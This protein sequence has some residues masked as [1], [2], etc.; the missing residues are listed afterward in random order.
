MSHADSGAL[1]RKLL[2][3]AEKS[4]APHLTEKALNSR[5]GPRSSWVPAA[6][7]LWRAVHEDVTALV[8]LL[9]VEPESVTVVP[10]TTNGRAGQADADALVLD[11]TILGVPV[12]V[13]A[14]LRRT[15]PMSVL[16]RPIDDLG[17]NLLN[18]VTPQGAATVTP[19]SAVL[20][21]D[22]T[23]ELADEL[24]LLAEAAAEPAAVSVGG[25]DSPSAM[26]LDALDAAALDE[27][28]ARLGA[29]LPAILDLVDGKRLL[30]PTEAA[31]FHELFG[32]APQTAPPPHALIVELNQPR[33]RG[34][35]YQYRRRHGLTEPAARASLSYDVGR[36]AARQT[37]QREPF[38]S[39][40]IRLW[41][42]AERLDPDIDR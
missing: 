31:V 37:G 36:M 21:D 8:V 26:T 1:P 19:L 14:E 20:L 35:V 29:T 38:W 2:A 4:A 25:G 5:L 7:Q 18:R 34:L 6:G 40:R 11:G 27:A 13:W 22:V 41:A 30:T 17:A 33:W 28:A 3:L 9:T 12:T 39:D 16:D 10:V 15:L 42:Q 23:A 24:E 32:T